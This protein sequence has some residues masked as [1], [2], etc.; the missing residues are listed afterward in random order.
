[1]QIFQ[2]S[3]I[4]IVHD[5]CNVIYLLE[6]LFA[7]CCVL[8][9]NEA[10]VPNLVCVAFECMAFAACVGFELETFQIWELLYSNVDTLLTVRLFD[11]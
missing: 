1:M 11:L 2:L 5:R 3:V 4:S 8:L 9:V 10:S 6:R 7:S